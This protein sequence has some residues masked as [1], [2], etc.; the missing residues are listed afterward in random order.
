MTAARRRPTIRDVARRS[1]YSVGTVSRALNGYADVAEQTRA[2]ILQ[3]ATELEYQPEA[4]ARSLVTRRTQVIGVFLDTG[5]DHPDLQHPFFH[6]VLVGLKGALGR[7]GY[8]LLLFAR[9]GSQNVFGSQ[10]YLD[11]C[12]QHGVDGVVLMGQIA[13]AEL[14]PLVRSEIPCVGVD[15]DPG[16]GAVL[17]CSDNV[18]GGELAVEHLYE[19]GHRRIATMT[20]LLDTPPGRDRLQGYR[21]AL[22]EHR[23]AYRDEYV[24]YCDFYVDSGSRAME[25]LL[26]LGEPPTAVFAASDLTAIGAMRTCASAGV[27]VPEDISIVGYDD[28]PLADHIQPSLTTI[29]QDKLHLGAQGGRALVERIEGGDLPSSPV[30]M[31]V[32]VIVRKS[33]A[34]ASVPA[35]VP[36]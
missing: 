5:E 2:R 28:I 29:R 21:K 23:L 19:L 16:D 17:V 1:G 33:T 27:R 34:L 31:P 35:P 20:G 24:A 13:E 15:L 32:E 26:R 30:T 4:A 10:S 12:R 18:A 8:D 7:A 3:V 36:D 6:E 22:Q 11:R 9:D 14:R 25:E